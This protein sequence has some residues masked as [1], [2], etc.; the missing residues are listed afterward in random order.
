[1]LAEVRMLRSLG[2]CHSPCGGNVD[3]DEG[4]TSALLFQPREP[5]AFTCRRHGED[6]E[7][8]HAA[9]DISV[10]GLPKLDKVVGRSPK[11]CSLC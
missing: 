9:T 8:L 7:G 5:E 2:A 1:M 10:Q 4:W 6:F 11:S 3:T